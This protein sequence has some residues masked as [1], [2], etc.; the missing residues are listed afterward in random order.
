M[1]TAMS[2]TRGLLVGIALLWLAACFGQSIAA[3]PSEGNDVA[4]IRNI[5]GS[6]WDRPES[7]VDVGPVVV[8]GDHAIAG[9][10]QG[11]HG[12]RALLSRANGKWRVV[13]CAGDALKQADTLQQTG[14]AASIAAKLSSDL[15]AAEMD[16]PA[17][18]L[19]RFASFKGLVEMPEKGHDEGQ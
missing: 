4:A 12:G 7:K 2:T 14:I 3:D 19:A 1:V 16:V 9:W 17:E 18:R 13:L 15:I 8:T 6:Q 5:I 11:D 10:T